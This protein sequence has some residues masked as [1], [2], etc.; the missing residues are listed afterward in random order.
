M[1]FVPDLGELAYWRGD[2][3]ILSKEVLPVGPEGEAAA[4]PIACV[5]EAYSK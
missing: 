1:M 3:V 5:P 2:A 4:L